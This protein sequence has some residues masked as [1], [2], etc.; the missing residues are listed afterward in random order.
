MEIKY[1]V[2]TC[3]RSHLKCGVD[4]VTAGIASGVGSL[5]GGASSA[6][7]TT[8]SS[9]RNV[10]KQIQAQKEENKLNRDWQTA[11]AEKARQFESSEWTRQFNMQNEYNTPAAQAARLRE[12]NINPAVYFSG[13]Q[14]NQGSSPQTAPSGHPASGTMGLSPVSFQPLDLQLPNMISSVTGAIKSLSETQKTDV[15]TE[16]LKR[17]MN[18]F[19]KKLSADA[20]GQELMNSLSRLSALFQEARLP[21]ASKQALAD[22]DKTLGEIDLL[23]EKGISEQEQQKVLRSTAALNKSLE[24]VHNEDAKWIGR[25]AISKINNMAADSARA[26]ADANKSRAEAQTIDESRKWDI[27][28][29]RWQNMSDYI[30]AH[31]KLGTMREQKESIREQLRALKND[32][33]LQELKKYDMEAYYAAERIILGRGSENDFHMLTGR[34]KKFV[35]DAVVAST[36]K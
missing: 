1:F 18:D 5:F 14:V 35:K 30:D 27:N 29:K 8:A 19:L 25:I 6:A 36:I 13:S 34:I 21:Y 16:Q 10:D 20:T 33:E 4:P 15:E 17:G 31:T 12:A 7:I 28:I 2:I 24:N 22:L 26:Y 9:E 32:N 23:N 3:P 11:E